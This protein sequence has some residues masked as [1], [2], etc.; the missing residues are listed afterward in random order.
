MLLVLDKTIAETRSKL[1]EGIAEQSPT[2]LLQCTLK[3]AAKD[4]LLQLPLTLGDEVK[5]RAELAAA[6]A[7]TADAI[8]NPPRIWS[9]ER[10]C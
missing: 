5:Q 6:V 8:A 9:W 4:L 1:L 3:G 10:L 2:H 7:F